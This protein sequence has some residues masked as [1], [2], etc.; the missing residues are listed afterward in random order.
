MITE[1]SEG[2]I[3]LELK[4]FQGRRFPITS[5]K[6]SGY[7]SETKLQNKI[8]NAIKNK[9]Y[10]KYK[11]NSGNLIMVMLILAPTLLSMP[12]I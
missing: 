8:N 2:R 11:I 10:F 6:H 5:Y 1:S 9:T 12:K 4:D 3:R 7:Q